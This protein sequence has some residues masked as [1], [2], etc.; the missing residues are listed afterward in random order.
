[1]PPAVPP[2]MTE[3]D[4][5]IVALLARIAAE[6]SRAATFVA[7]FVNVA[8]AKAVNETWPVVEGIL[9]RSQAT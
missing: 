4:P 3:T 1:M 6:P 2:A 8:V 5:R 7:A 9:F